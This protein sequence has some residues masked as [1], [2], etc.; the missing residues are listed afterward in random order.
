MEN[1]HQVVVRHRSRPSDSLSDAERPME[2]RSPVTQLVEAEAVTFEH[3][4]LT[5]KCGVPAG[6]QA[7]AG[8]DASAAAVTKR[9]SLHYMRIAVL[10][11]MGLAMDA[12]PGPLQTMGVHK[13]A[14]RQNRSRHVIAAAVHGTLTGPL[15]RKT[16]TVLSSGAGLPVQCQQVT[17]EGSFSEADPQAASSADTCTQVCTL[18]SCFPASCFSGFAS[19]RAHITRQACTS[20]CSFINLDI[21]AHPIEC[22]GAAAGSEGQRTRV[23]MARVSGSLEPTIAQS[24]DA[25][26]LVVITRSARLV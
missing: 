9:A 18:I 16:T 8:H 24:I 1:A 4:S 23:G 7:H 14:E 22:K 15:I 5:L 26:M 25:Q 19:N 21:G 2:S 13:L 17:R 20:S 12:L 3:T 6:W 11:N 10:I